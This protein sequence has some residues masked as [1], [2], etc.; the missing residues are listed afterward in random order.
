MTAKHIPG[1]QGL[2]SGVERNTALLFGRI[3]TEVRICCAAS[4]SSGG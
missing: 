1:Q 4:K 2:A 3:G